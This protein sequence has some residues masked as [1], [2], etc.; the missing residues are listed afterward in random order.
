MP[1]DNEE[2]MQ[3]LQRASVLARRSRR[4]HVKRRIDE[5]GGNAETKEHGCGCAGHRSSRN[6]VAFDDAEA[7][8]GYGNHKCHGGS[9]RHGQNR[10]L[11]ILTMQD[12]ITQKDLAYLLG[13]RPQSLSEAL[14]KLETSKLIERKH[15]TEDKRVTNIFLTET[16]RT[17][18]E[19]VSEDR[20]KTAADIFSVLD[21]TEKEQFASI[22]EK[23][24]DKLDSD[25]SN[26]S[27]SK[28]AE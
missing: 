22:M 20:K 13:I 7:T 15:N 24:I 8:H 16:G 14:D 21:D 3:Q 17:R 10:I 18:A 11:A 1:V 6:A 2:L 19:K 28:K 23:L 25:L 9:G 4:A 12:G 26:Q 27:S 5:E